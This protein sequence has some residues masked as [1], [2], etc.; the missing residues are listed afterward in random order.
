MKGIRSKI[1]LDDKFR[2]GFIVWERGKIVRVG[3]GAPPRT[4]AKV[5]EDLRPLRV[6]P[7]L[8]DTLMHG[9]A[10]VDAT[11]GS[12]EEIAHMLE[13][14]GMAGT[15]TALAGFYPISNRRLSAATKRWN[16]AKL[17]RRRNH[18]APTRVPGWHV[19]G[20]FLPPAMAGGLPGE[21][22][23][24]PSVRRAEAFLKACR[25]WLS[26]TTLAP[27]LEQAWEA[28][29]VLTDA[30]VV[31]SIGHTEASHADCAALAAL[32][33]VAMTHLGHRMPAFTV[34]EPGPLG[35]ALEGRANWVAVIPD[36]VHV[37][38]ETLT[39][40]AD[41]P[42]LAEQLMFVSDSLSHAGTEDAR[43]DAGGRPLWRDGCVA[44]DDE[45]RLCGVLEPLSVLLRDRLH[46][47]TLTWG[48]VIRGACENPGRLMGDCGR[49]APGLRADFALVERDDTIKGFPILS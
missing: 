9:Y 20:P 39:L 42:Q 30:G 25:G 7:G 36:G 44:R 18:P 5:C 32:M 26:M 12:A 45:H 16:A 48:Q 33:P 3:K 49:F 21:A 29:G 27:E 11:E 4:L 19:E 37:A 47:G 38:P 6:I 24:E 40:L 31:V 41:Q 43:F 14:L 10:G 22:L 8:V 35:F 2:D 17:R 1:W 46:E 28:A 15:T 13:S 34:R 23:A